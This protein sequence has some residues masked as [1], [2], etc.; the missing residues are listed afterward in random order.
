[1]NAVIAIVAAAL[2]ILGVVLKKRGVAAALP[3]TAAAAILS[4]LLGIRGFSPEKVDGKQIASTAAAFAEVSG[5]KLARYLMERHDGARVLVLT[6]APDRS[7][8]RKAFLDSLT[9]EAGKRLSVSVEMPR[10]PAKLK[11]YLES[12]GLAPEDLN[13]ALAEA[14]EDYPSWLTTDYLDGWVS[15]QAGRVDVVVCTLRLPDDFQTSRVFGKPDAPR[16]VLVNSPTP[17]LLPL[18]DRGVVTAAITT[19]PNSDFWDLN[20]EQ[21]RDPEKAFDRRYLLVTRENLGDVRRRHPGLE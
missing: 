12:R 19:N 2:I 9:N 5:I 17:R 1:M 21:A 8:I 13:R 11:E 15:K 10:L 18:L 20:P 4:V 3:C 14:R 16:L 6:E 7:R